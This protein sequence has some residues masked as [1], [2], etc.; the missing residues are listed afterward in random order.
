MSDVVS[1]H[2]ETMMLFDRWSLLVFIVVWLLSHIVYF[3]YAY[4]YVLA[5]GARLQGRRPEARL[6]A[7]HHRQAALRVVRD[8]AAAAPPLGEHQGCRRV[9]CVRH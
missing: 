7:V 2:M 9:R 4:R 5:Q 6:R 1:R 8:A 3:G